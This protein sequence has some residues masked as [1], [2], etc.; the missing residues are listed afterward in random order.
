MAI[1]ALTTAPANKYNWGMDGVIVNLRGGLGNQLFQWA[2]GFALS[3]RLGCG[4]A[5]S[6]RGIERSNDLLDR[7][8]FELEYFSLRPQTKAADL[9]GGSL[10]RLVPGVVFEERGY[11]YDRRF[12]Q[13][14]SGKSLLGYFQSWKYFWSYEQEI[15]LKL[16]SNAG[17]TRDYA[18][19]SEILRRGQWIAV[20]VRRGD[21]KNHPERYPLVGPDYYSR[22]LRTIPSGGSHRV[23]V[24]SDDPDVARELVP[25]AD[26]VVGPLEISSPGDVIMLMSEANAVIGA[27]STLSWWGAFLNPGPSA[28]KI[29]PSEWLIDPAFKIGD[30]LPQGWTVVRDHDFN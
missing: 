5:I 13:L 8:K 29:F 25:G 20:H 26:L 15:R 18:E 11:G 27:N 17:Y 2:A 24:F 23:I 9:I 14:G 30:L 6:A 19:L 3:R 21:Y 28:S 12:R 10:R 4:L 16:R 22:A 7:R 1:G